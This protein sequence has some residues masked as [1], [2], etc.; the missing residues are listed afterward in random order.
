MRLT[1]S[2]YD[3][4][5][6]HLQ[7]QMQVP[8]TPLLIRQRLARCL[9]LRLQPGARKGARISIRSQSG[10]LLCIIAGALGMRITCGCHV[11]AL[12]GFARP[13]YQ[14]RSRLPAHL[15]T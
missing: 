8:G 3:A 12:W 10:P 1:T 15:R 7:L 14:V 5:G 9:H 2:T 4:S 6:P 13:L 11:Q